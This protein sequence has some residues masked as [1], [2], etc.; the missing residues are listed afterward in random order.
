MSHSIDYSQLHNHCGL[1]YAFT[2]NEGQV[3]DAATVGNETRCINHST[4]PIMNIEAQGQ[5]YYSHS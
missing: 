4:G 2:L 3:L 1:N 5:S